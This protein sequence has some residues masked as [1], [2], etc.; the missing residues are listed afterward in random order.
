[1]RLPPKSDNLEH[2]CANTCG[3]RGTGREIVQLCNSDLLCPT[4]NQHNNRSMCLTCM[5]DKH[6]TKV[7]LLKMPLSSAPPP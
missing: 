4:C 5:A 2:D 7:Q 1:M 3:H 6:D